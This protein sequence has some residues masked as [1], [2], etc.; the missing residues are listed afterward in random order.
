MTQLMN[1]VEKLANKILNKGVYK[2][3]Y[4]ISEHF[5]RINWLKKNTNI[6]IQLN[7]IYNYEPSK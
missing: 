2:F 1:N 4:S 6:P 5:K 3:K 7:E